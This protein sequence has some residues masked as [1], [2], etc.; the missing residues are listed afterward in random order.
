[1]IWWLMKYHPTHIPMLLPLL[2]AS[3]LIVITRPTIEQLLELLTH[4]GADSVDCLGTHWCYRQKYGWS[5]YQFFI[6]VWYILIYI[7]LAWASWDDVKSDF[8]GQGAHFAHDLS[9]MITIQR[10]FNLSVIPCCVTI[11]Y[12]YRFLHMLLLCCVQNCS[13]CFIKI[14]M[15]AKWTFYEIWFTVKKWSLESA[16]CSISMG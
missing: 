5:Q 12:L 2:P 11:L 7:K 13:D 15:S 3:V 6:T 10:K 9:I 1:M 4:I 14:W 16:P 8:T